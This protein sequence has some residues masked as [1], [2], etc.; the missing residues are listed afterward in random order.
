MVV[1][2]QEVAGVERE[3]ILVARLAHKTREELI[4]ALEATRGWDYSKPYKTGVLQ[5]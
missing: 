4:A 5:T 1:V 3:P 2:E